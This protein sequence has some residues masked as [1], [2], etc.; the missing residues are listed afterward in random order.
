MLYKDR[1]RS[2]TVIQHYVNGAL[3]PRGNGFFVCYKDCLYL[4]TCLHIV[5]CYHQDSQG[6]FYR[7]EELVF[8]LRTRIGQAVQNY[9][10]PVLNPRKWRTSA[11]LDILADVAAIELDRD[12]L[13]SEYDIEPWREADL[14]PDPDLP[15]GARIWIL[16]HPK[17]YGDI[18]IPYDVCALMKSPQ[19]ED[20]Q[21]AIRVRASSDISFGHSGSLVYRVIHDDQT[22]RGRPSLDTH[23]QAVGIVAGANTWDRRTPLIE[24]VA[25]ALPIFNSTEDLFDEDGV[26]II[27]KTT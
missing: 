14:L 2:I 4:V 11:A 17:N 24:Y 16:T 10:V 3:E 22:R 12:E 6:N 20:R 25:R 13:L 26:C 5:R 9:T 8:K 23:I 18:P 21:A 15:R 27:K 19:P 1:N 7:P